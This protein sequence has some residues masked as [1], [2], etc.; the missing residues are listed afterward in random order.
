M[1][2]LMITGPD[3]V[4]ILGQMATALRDEG[5]NITDMY[6]FFCIFQQ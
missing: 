6:V 1:V 3:D 2:N 5:L 4:G